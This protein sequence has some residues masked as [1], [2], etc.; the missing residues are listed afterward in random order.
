MFEEEE[1]DAV[2]RRHAL[3]ERS[4]GGDDDRRHCVGACDRARR[5]D[6]RKRSRPAAPGARLRRLAAL[7]RRTLALMHGPTSPGRR[8]GRPPRPRRRTSRSAVR[9]RSLLPALVA[10]AASDP[11]LRLH[12]SN[13]APAPHAG[14]A[15]IAA[16]PASARARALSRAGGA[17]SS[18]E[19]RSLG[20]LDSIRRFDNVLH[21]WRHTCRPTWRSLWSPVQAAR[22]SLRRHA[23]D[24]PGVR[25]ESR[26]PVRGPAAASAASPTTS[27]SSRSFSARPAA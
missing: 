3:S 8:L 1:R 19:K 11:V 18:H 9:R 13:P 6:A 25:D 4:G 22:A 10:G 16:A 27:S 24:V 26:R 20:Q 12:G 5:A 23:T 7:K 2:L 14:P 17:R 15:P 21:R